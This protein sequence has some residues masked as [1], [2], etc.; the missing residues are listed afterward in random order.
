[1]LSLD[2]ILA[3]IDGSITA[4][5]RAPSP[6]TRVAFAASVFLTFD[7]MRMQPKPFD[8]DE[9]VRKV[10]AER[11]GSTVEAS[12]SDISKFD[13]EQS[14]AADPTDYPSFVDDLYS[15]CW[16]YSP[17]EYEQT[18]RLFIDRLAMNELTLDLSERRA[19]DIGCGS[20]RNTVALV[21]LGASEAI[22]VDF[23]KKAI[24]EASDRLA[25]LPEGDRISLMVGSATSL[26]PDWTA[27]FDFVVSNGVVHHT[28][29]PTLGVQE[30]ARI[31]RHG[32]SA[33]FMVYG[34]G[35][36]FWSLT[37]RLRALLEGVSPSR[38]HEVLVDL[39]VSV[40]KRFFCLD[41]W[42]TTYQEQ[43]TRSEFETRLHRAGFE[44][45]RYLGRGA[46][47]DAVERLARFP[48]EADLIGDPDMRYVVTKS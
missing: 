18:V 5:Q 25:H 43:V 31:C 32:G 26:P 22:G 2:Q 42:F 24:A 21:R 15:R 14:A 48:E 6:S 4:V 29:D 13:L 23:S 47:H 33:F 34:T 9:F 45:L 20:A 35:G 36:L 19:A 8:R 3:E 11:D 10:I 12:Q 40:H 17:S 16:S 44:S 27:A 1:M 7:S 30:V 41:H 39:G 38:A 28:P 37:S 46:S